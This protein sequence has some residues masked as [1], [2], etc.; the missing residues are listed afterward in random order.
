VFKVS[1][2]SLSPNRMEERTF[3]HLERKD[4]TQLYTCLIVFPLQLRGEHH[5]VGVVRPACDHDSTIEV[6]R[7]STKRYRSIVE[8]SPMGMHMYTLEEGDRLVFENYNPAAER[9]LGVSHDQFIGKTIEEAFPPLAD[10]EALSAGRA[11]G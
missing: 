11:Q 5:F 10:P 9:I 2:E 8:S 6:L 1:I 3:I 4:G 7:D